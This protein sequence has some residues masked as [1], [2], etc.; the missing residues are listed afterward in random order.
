MAQTSNSSAMLLD[1]LSTNQERESLKHSDSDYIEEQ[2]ALKLKDDKV[3]NS[4]KL[5]TEKYTLML[6]QWDVRDQ[7]LDRKQD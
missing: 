4:L 2:I 7:V 6:A 5:M 3:F 1:S